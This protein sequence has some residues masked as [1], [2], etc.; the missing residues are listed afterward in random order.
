MIKFIDNMLNRITMYR[1]ILY[2][3]IA[4]LAFA[5]ALS[6]AGILPYDPFGLLFSVGFLVAVCGVTNRVFARTFG[7]PPNVESS[8]ISAL[9]LAL[10]ITPIRGYADL[11]FLLWA[12]VLAMAS[13]YILTIRG[14]HIFN[15]VAFA[16][17]LTALTIDQA[18]TWWVGTTWMLIPV[19][20]GGV[21]IVRKIRHFDLVLSFLIVAVLT[22]TV[23]GALTG[24]LLLDSLQRTVLYTPL[25][26]FAFVIV[27]EPLTT[28]PTRHLQIVYGAL[29]GFLF[30]PQIHIGALYFTPELAMLA[31]NVF[32]WLVSP[33][34]KLVLRLKEKIQ[35]APDIWDFIF[36]P[37][38]RFAFAPGQYMEWTL[39]HDDP[40]Q[41][42]NRRYF[43]LASAPTENELRLG[44]KFYP[45]SSTYKQQMLAMDAHSEI[46]AAQLAG[47]FTLPAD[48]NQKCVFIAGGIGITPFRSMIKYLLDRQERRPI[49]V[50]YANR[51]LGEIVYQD[52]FEMARRVLG[53]KVVYTVSDRKSVPAGWQG[54]VG[55][56]DPLLIRAEVPDYQNCVFYISGPNAMVEGTSQMLRKMG[57]HGDHIKTDFFPGLA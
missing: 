46:V 15:P 57:V 13:K 45:N 24:E 52:V 51:T 12:G 21:L 17:A 20:I 10:I 11:W 14:K 53:I 28:P 41:R 2:Y 25:F 44:V 22:M 56:V 26:F 5:F 34:V 1:L 47:D 16:V 43:T 30:A 42:G 33:K 54:R 3:L 4:L 38:G 35:I 9:I 19:L 50:I 27:T 6:A 49:T 31:A 55:H 40:D 7:I 23:A 37:N 8:Y 48:P 29:T 18:A 39:G 32:S 36:V